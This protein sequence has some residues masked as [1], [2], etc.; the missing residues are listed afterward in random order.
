MHHQV[1]DNLHIYVQKLQD[2]ILKNSQIYCQIQSE[3]LQ[4]NSTRVNVV[5]VNTRVHCMPIYVSK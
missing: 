2:Q 5:Y 4:S 1:S 3:N